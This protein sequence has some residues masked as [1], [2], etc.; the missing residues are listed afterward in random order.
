MYF[1][2]RTCFELLQH[3]AYILFILKISNFQPLGQ[4]WVL[5][6]PDEVSNCNR[7]SLHVHKLKTNCYEISGLFQEIKEVLN[8]KYKLL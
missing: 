5:L 7:S 6:I 8:T 2:I 3:F 1:C 4:R